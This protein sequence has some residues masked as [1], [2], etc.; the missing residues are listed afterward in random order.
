MLITIPLLYLNTHAHIKH[1][2]VITCP[3]REDGGLLVCLMPEG[4]IRLIII[5]AYQG[6]YAPW[7][8]WKTLY[9]YLSPEKPLKTLD[10]PIYP[11]KTMKNRAGYGIIPKLFNTFQKKRLNK[12][13]CIACS[14]VATFLRVHQNVLLSPNNGI[15]HSKTCQRLYRVLGKFFG[16]CFKYPWKTSRKSMKKVVENP[17]FLEL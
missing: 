16:I 14:M 5:C 4:I 10:L 12:L 9:L 8:S 15:I 17:I 3:S 1:K 6:S 7:K 2:V 11:W 13:F